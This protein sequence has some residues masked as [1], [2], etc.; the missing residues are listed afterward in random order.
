[1]TG[2][3]RDVSFA[4]TVATIPFA[5]GLSAKECVAREWKRHG[6]AP[7]CDRSLCEITHTCPMKRSALLSITFIL[8]L[9]SLSHSADAPGVLAPILQSFVDEQYKRGMADGEIAH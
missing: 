2:L 1:M 5:I 4:I 3:S 6:F 8:G 9:A 7:P